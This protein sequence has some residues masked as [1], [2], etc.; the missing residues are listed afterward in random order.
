MHIQEFAEN[1][2]D[3]VHFDTIHGAMRVPWTR[4]RLPWLR[5]RHESKWEAGDDDGHVATFSDRAALWFRGREIPRA[6]ASAEVKFLGP[7]GVV[8]FLFDVPDLGRMLLFQTYLPVA[9]LRQRVHF[10]WFAGRRFPRLVAWYLAGS[11]IAQ[12]RADVPIWEGKVYRS[13]PLLTKGDGP[14]VRMRRWYRQFYPG[15]SEP[16]A[17]WLSAPRRAA[18]AQPGRDR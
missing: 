15:G 8:R 4:L 16:S 7:G 2:V 13:D 6:G 18:P 1:A 9:P 14:V 10:R 3:P 12:W 11:W 5:I 17:A